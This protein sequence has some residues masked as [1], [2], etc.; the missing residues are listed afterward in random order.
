LDTKP[1]FGIFFIAQYD[2]KFKQAIVEEYLKGA[3][4][5]KV[6]SAKF[7][8]NRITIKGWFN[9]YRHHGD[10]GLRKR[11]SHYNARFK[12]SILNQMW[13]QGLSFNQV[14][15]LFD[16]RRVARLVSGWARHYYEGGL[17][18]LEPKSRARPKKMK[19]PEI[20]PSAPV[21]PGS[22]S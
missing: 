19:N 22:S 11:P 18:A 10:A 3:S 12:F 16:L 17:D 20:P 5:Y 6:L 13:Q 15:A 9:L 21:Q 7:G 1:I 2:E 4:G 14:A 8:A